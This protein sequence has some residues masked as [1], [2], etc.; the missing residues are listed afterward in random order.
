MAIIDEVAPSLR[1]LAHRPLPVQ[2]TP[3]GLA[4]LLHSASTGDERAFAE[5]YHLT[6]A[7][8]YGLARRV[9][10]NSAQAE[11]VT[12]EAYLEIWRTSPRF[13]SLRG[14]AISW[15]MV[16]VH[17]RAVDRVRAEE[18]RNARE[19]RDQRQTHAPGYADDTTSDIVFASITAERVRAALSL[20]PPPQR[21]ALE[22]TY[23]GGYTNA[24][25]AN[26]T[27]VPIGTTKSRLRSGL[28]Q[29]RELMLES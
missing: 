20:L 21:E 22:L 25:V 16:I 10:R 1:E 28:V 2:T 23:F 6:S 29:L 18:S 9:L 3:R 19:E 17:R 24:Q 26:L 15:M 13:D 8:V 12:Q 5:L 11:E 14:S 27:G 7:R 4:A